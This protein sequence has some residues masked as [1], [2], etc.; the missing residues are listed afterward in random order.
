E[1][2]RSTLCGWMRESGVLLCPLYELLKQRVFSSNVL[3]TADTTVPVLDLLLDKTK[4]GRFW[5]YLGDVLNPYT[6]YDFTMTRRRDGP[7]KF[8]E[9][10][11]GY[12]HADAYGGYDGIY[13]ESGGKILE[14][15]C[16]A[17]ARRKFFDAR[18]TAPAH[19]PTMLAMIGRLYEVEEQARSLS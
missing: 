10:F 11:Q 8:L 16:W 1:F 7:Q 3:W 15:A 13:L 6:V 17:H 18:H 19:A 5:A 12:L 2:S 4:T 9:G 14:V